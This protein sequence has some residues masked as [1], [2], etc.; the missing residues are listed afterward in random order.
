MLPEIVENNKRKWQIIYKWKSEWV[1][2]WSDKKLFKY[3][4]NL[5][6]GYTL[7]EI[8]WGYWKGQCFTPWTELPKKLVKEEE[9]DIIDE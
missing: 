2:D 9:T 5:Q 6:Q 4:T 3:I 7:T 8:E 1:I